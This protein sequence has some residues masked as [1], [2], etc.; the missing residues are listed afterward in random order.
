[1]HHSEF[2]HHKVKLGK[3]GYKHDDRTL[4][5]AEF[6]KL[7]DLRLPAAFDFD[8]GRKTIPNRMWGNDQYG[9]CVIAG[10]S[11][12]LL[13]LE[14]VEAWTTI[15]LTDNDAITRYKSLTGCRQPGDQ[16]DTGLVILDSLHNWR[17][18]G[19][20]TYYKGHNFQIDAYGELDPNDH[21]QIKFAIYLLHGV[22]WGIALPVAAQAMIRDGKLDYNGETG[23]DW[24]PGSWGGHCVYSKAY[25]ENGVK[26]LTWDMEIEMTWNFIH[27]FVDEA[28]GVVDSL[29]S[30]RK[31]GHLDVQ[32]ME[33]KLNEITTK[34]DQ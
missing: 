28:W 26:I 9:D 25:T 19:Y 34:V 7:P 2:Q 29:D 14:R 10:E 32:A 12:Q 23:P 24:E 8:T 17:N 33:A 27:K 11:N 4:K 22:Q 13:R 16:N 20:L 30:W 5:L 3:K 1:M 18:V 31:T 21:D 15:P 6:F